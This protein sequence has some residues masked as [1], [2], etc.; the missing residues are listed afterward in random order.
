MSGLMDLEDVMLE[1][2]VFSYCSLYKR[3]IE[4]FVPMSLSMTLIDSSRLQRGTSSRCG[5]VAIMAFHR[6]VLVAPF[7]IGPLTGESGN[8]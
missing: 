8:S 3:F 6:I 2:V 5:R 4:R 7:E 1:S